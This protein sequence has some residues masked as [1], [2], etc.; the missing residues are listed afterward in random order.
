MISFSEKQRKWR[1][2]EEKK[3]QTREMKNLS[4]IRC[5]SELCLSKQVFDAMSEERKRGDVWV[6]SMNTAKAISIKL[7]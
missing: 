6:T 3:R 2:K 1:K 4:C 5:P 7:R